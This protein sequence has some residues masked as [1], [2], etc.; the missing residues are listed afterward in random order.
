MKSKWSGNYLNLRNIEWV[1]EC[2]ITRCL[3]VHND[4]IRIVKYEYLWCAG[5]VDRTDRQWMHACRIAWLET[6]LWKSHFGD[7]ERDWRSI[8]LRILTDCMTNWMNDSLIG[9]LT[10]SK[11]PAAHGLVHWRSFFWRCSTITFFFQGVLYL[12]SSEEVVWNRMIWEMLMTGFGKRL[13]WLA[14]R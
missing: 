5:H 14:S 4:F 9:C 12:A 3:M 7:R 11:H 8:E 2:Y 10:F 1:S 13:S 6:I